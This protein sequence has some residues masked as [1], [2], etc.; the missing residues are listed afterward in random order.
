MQAAKG[1]VSLR[2][3]PFF[4]F[5]PFFACVCV[6]DLLQ[7]DS[8]GNR[9]C[10]RLTNKPLIFIGKF[11]KD[12]RSRRMGRA[13]CGADLVNKRARNIFNGLLRVPVKK[14]IPALNLI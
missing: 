13:D 10:E 14:K 4:Y 7:P 1:G 11:E 5:G 12:R 2:F 3:G 9:L 6:R 8:K